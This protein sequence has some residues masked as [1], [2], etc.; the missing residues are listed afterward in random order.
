MTKA[1][2]AVFQTPSMAQARGQKP[3]ILAEPGADDQKRRVAHVR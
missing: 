2:A 1:F 3:T